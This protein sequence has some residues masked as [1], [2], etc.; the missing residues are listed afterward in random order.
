MALATCWDSPDTSRVAVE[1]PCPFPLDPLL[2]TSCL[3]HPSQQA[4]PHPEW[5]P[6][7]LS[8][9]LRNLILEEE[10]LWT[11]SYYGVNDHRT[12]IFFLTFGNQGITRDPP[13]GLFSFL[14]SCP[15]KSPVRT[16]HLSPRSSG[17]P[18]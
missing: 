16:A 1:L 8:T 17:K 5:G 9:S 7:R 10:G 2:S 6:S 13:H 4:Q 3:L 15:S 14:Q 18:P 11:N 12:L